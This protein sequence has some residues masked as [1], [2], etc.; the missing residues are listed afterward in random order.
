MQAMSVDCY[1]HAYASSGWATDINGRFNSIVIK[2]FSISRQILEMSNDDV[3]DPTAVS[4]AYRWD[5]KGLYNGIT[6]VTYGEMLTLQ[7]ARVRYLPANNSGPWK[8]YLLQSKIHAL[9]SQYV[10]TDTV[11]APGA[12]ANIDYWDPHFWFAACRPN[13]LNSNTTFYWIDTI[14]MLFDGYE[15]KQ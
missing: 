5:R 6:A 7:D 12:G 15:E 9:P 4:I 13:N 10:M 11:S 2:G 14:E 1:L 3:T 8:G